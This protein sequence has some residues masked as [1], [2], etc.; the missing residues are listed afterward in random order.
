M[1][2]RLTCPGSDPVDDKFAHRRHGL[3]A[4]PLV[5]SRPDAIGDA[6]QPE[7]AAATHRISLQISLADISSISHL[8]LVQLLLILCITLEARH[9]KGVYRRL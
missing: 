5:E 8:E 9:P 7:V 2:P 6:N 1:K 4:G 3:L